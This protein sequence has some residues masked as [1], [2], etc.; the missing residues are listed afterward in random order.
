MEP[1]PPTLT[2]PSSERPGLKDRSSS[3]LLS[4]VSARRKRNEAELRS[5]FFSL[6]FKIDRF[7]SYW[8]GR[9]RS[10]CSVLPSRLLGGRFSQ[11][12]WTHHRSQCWTHVEGELGLVFLSLQPFDERK[13]LRLSFSSPFSFPQ[14][15]LAPGTPVEHATP[16]SVKKGGDN[17]SY[18]ISFVLRSLFPLLPSRLVL[19]CLFF[20]LTR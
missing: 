14:L 8:R 3:E 20:F 2:P 4:L 17:E 16:V 10:A 5:F 7:R 1:L 11:V 12:E 18:Q 9:E 15:T 13:N 6:S 19:L